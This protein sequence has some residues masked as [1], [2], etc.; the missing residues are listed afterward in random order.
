MLH[1][2]DSLA[3]ATPDSWLE[4]RSFRQDIRRVTP[5]EIT[6]TTADILEKFL[7]TG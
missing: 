1:F 7:T 3:E 5:A 6:A 4:V 2:L